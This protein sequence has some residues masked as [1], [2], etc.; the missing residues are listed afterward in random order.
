MV[1]KITTDYEK[2]TNELATR[3]GDYEMFYCCFNVE[4][5]AEGISLEEWEKISE[6]IE[7]INTYLYKIVVLKIINEIINILCRRKFIK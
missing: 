7:Y 3:F 4:Y 6:L 1:K 2:T 5:G